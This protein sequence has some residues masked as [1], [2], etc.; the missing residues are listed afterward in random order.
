MDNLSVLNKNNIVHL[1]I[2]LTQ[3]G[4]DLGSTHESS[5]QIVSR[6]DVLTL[7]RELAFA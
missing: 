6:Y 5:A 4:K 1:I 3:I 7:P 2:I